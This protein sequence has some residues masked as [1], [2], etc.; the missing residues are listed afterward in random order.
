MLVIG[1]LQ[2]SRRV[3]G[4]PAPR[5]NLVGGYSG[6]WPSGRGEWGAFACFTFPASSS[7]PAF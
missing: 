5:I 6:S 4:F 2:T 3:C 7:L 1:E